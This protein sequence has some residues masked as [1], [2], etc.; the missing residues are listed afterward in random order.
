MTRRSLVLSAAL[1]AFPSLLQALTLECSI[2]RSNAGGGYITDVYIL[3]HDAASGQAIVSDGLILY[4]NDEQPMTAQVAEDTA[5]KLVL[6][7]KVRMTNRTGQTANMQFR[8]SF[9]K[10]DQTLVVRAAPGGDYSNTFEGRGRCRP[11]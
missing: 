11:V 3:Q 9:F 6:T 7:W 10:G 1:M 2:N 8:A 5:K 4:F